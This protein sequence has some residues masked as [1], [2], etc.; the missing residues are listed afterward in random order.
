ML[1]DGNHLNGMSTEMG[2]EIEKLE[3]EIYELAGEEFNIKSTKQLGHILFEKLGLPTVK[4]TTKTKSYST[5]QSVLEALA[6]KGT[7]N[8]MLEVLDF[9]EVS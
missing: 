3:A 6:A 9:I 8:V 5:D 1:I 2:T 7:A 4:K